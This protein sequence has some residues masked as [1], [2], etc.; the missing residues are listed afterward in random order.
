[1]RKNAKTPEQK[2]EEF[3]SRVDTTGE[4]HLYT[5]SLDAHGYGNFCKGPPQ[6]LQVKAHRFAYELHTGR[7]YPPWRPVGHLCKNRHCV[8][9]EHLKLGREKPKEHFLNRQRGPRPELWKHG[10]SEE[11]K[12]LNMAFLR[13]RCQARYRK[14]I[15]QMT[16][17]EFVERWAGRHSET[18]IKSTCTVMVRTDPEGVW[19]LENTMLT[20]RGKNQGRMMRLKKEK[21]LPWT[22]RF[23]HK[24]QN[25]TDTD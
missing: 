11:L 15:W 1:M 8:R 6:P 7:S 13:A 22:H 10:P 9:I 12:A 24:E 14:E 20:N 23:N 19:S 5:G 2:I 25:E 18:G 17:D 4:C 21:N 3:W 16:F